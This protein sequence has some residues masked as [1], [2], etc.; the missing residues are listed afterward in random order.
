MKVERCKINNLFK[1][2]V[3]KHRKYNKSSQKQIEEGGR[4]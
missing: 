1:I 2:P 3:K 4:E